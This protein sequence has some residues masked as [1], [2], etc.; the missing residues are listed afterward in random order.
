MLASS[1][2]ARR[3]RRSQADEVHQLGESL[4]KLYADGEYEKAI[5]AGEELLTL[6]SRQSKQANPLVLVKLAGA[7]RAAKNPGKAEAT[8]KRAIEV[9]EG[10]TDAPNPLLG[11][12]LE[13]YSCFLAR[14]GNKAQAIGMQKRAVSIIA[15]LPKDFRSGP[16]SGRVTP[17]QTISLPQ[18]KYPADARN[19]HLEATVSVLV[20][21][22]E[23]G[24]PLT[25]CAESG[26][27]SLA[28]AGEEVAF[29]ARWTPTM[30]DNLPVRVNGRVIYHFVAK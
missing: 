28:V 10:S 14:N 7:Y 18:P 11:H 13:R 4:D 5:A 8:Y 26:D 16:I 19:Q 17:G 25:A 29:N 21:I 23:T 2:L 1:S 15:P 30:L 24:K 12:A 3:P 9:L 22:D 20:L 6:A 27:E